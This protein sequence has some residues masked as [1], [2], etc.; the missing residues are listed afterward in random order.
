[1]TIKSRL[2]L[3]A[4]VSLA[5]LS[6]VGLVG[7]I[8]MDRTTKS[9]VYIEDLSQMR[10]LSNVDALI[11][12]NH[13]QYL[14]TLQHD[15]SQPHIVAL[16]DHPTEMHLDHM[17]RIHQR[18]SEQFQAFSEFPA[19]AEFLSNAQSYLD[20]TH[21]YIEETKKGIVMYEQNR[22]HDANIHLLNTMNPL[23]NQTLEAGQ[24]FRRV[25]LGQST[26]VSEDANSQAQLLSYTL[27][28]VLLLAFLIVAVLAISVIKNIRAGI[29]TT[30]NKV[31]NIA[32]TMDF[33][34]RFDKRNDELNQIGQS[35]NSMLTEVQSA[36]NETNGVVGAIAQGD[37]SKRIEADLVGDLANLKSG[38]NGSAENVEFMM[39]ELDK[40]MAALNEGQFDVKMDP[41]VPDAFSQRVDKALS[42]I[43]EVVENINRVMDKMSNGKFRHRVEV[44]ARGQ[45][46]IMKNNVNSAMDGLEHAMSDITKVV[47]A[48][49]KGDLTK[50]I[51]TQY[52]GE[53]RILT[54]AVN[55]S[56]GKLVEVVAVAL[57][58]AQ[59]VNHASLEVAQGSLDLSD[60]VQQQAAAIEQSTATMT[61]FS[62]AVQNNAQQAADATALERE[63]EKQSKTAAEVMKQTIESMA[64]I[65]ASSHKISDIVTLID[66]IAFQTNL[67]AL[68]A[69]VEAA[70]AGEHGRGF[71][72]VAGEVRAL[73]QKSAE[74]A[75]DITALINE[76]VTRI[77]QGTRLANESGDVILNITG[78][79]E[80][81]AQMSEQIASASIEQSEGVKQLQLAMNQ[82]D[83][84]TQQNAALVEETSAAAESMREQADLL[85][86]QMQF[87][88]T[89]EGV[90][91]APRLADSKVANTPALKSPAVKTEQKK[92]KTLIDDQ[93]WAEF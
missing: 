61:S 19:S 66:G 73:A 77:D 29:D 65:Q 49:S 14:L 91:V 40:V 89:R 12:R 13:N 48:L 58:A 34:T 88:Q 9:M 47:V 17:H 11:L 44:E 67:L 22:F 5:A 42:S 78:A 64:A 2:I 54:E 56:V 43:N 37:Y 15:P 35:L 86:E 75:K 26:Q 24:D 33:S 76:S 25:L 81:A 63:V 74:A 62:D 27:L 21:R 55:Q 52:H 80:K 6:V 30:V 46:A 32:N 41:R 68:N 28:S 70:R 92:S 79:I 16:H 39:A 4:V 50:T 51:D 82:I 93:E 85:S 38:V 72:V 20:L 18:I 7:H 23:L 10:S 3:L 83:E 84:G 57:D 31:T 59:L 8:G 1:M 90:S 53:L 45:L 69:A 36:I 71:A 60:R 87:F